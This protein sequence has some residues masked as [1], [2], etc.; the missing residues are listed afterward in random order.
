MSILIIAVV[1][2]AIVLLEYYT[3]QKASQYYLKCFQDRKTVIRLIL[4]TTAIA[5]ISGV[6]EGNPNRI[7]GH[8]VS[9]NENSSVSFVHWLI[10]VLLSWL[11][12]QRWLKTKEGNQLS[13]STALVLLVLQSL[14]L[15]V[16]MLVLAFIAMVVVNTFGSMFMR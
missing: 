15:I 3:L 5:I 8:I 9:T 1:C 13:I 7:S 11:L 6:L 14:L 2:I 12:Y 10:N 16:G 4:I